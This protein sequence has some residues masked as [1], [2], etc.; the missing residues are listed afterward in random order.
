[1]IGATFVPARRH[2][3]HHV[4]DLDTILEVHGQELDL[5]AVERAVNGQPITL[6][7]PEQYE[8]ARQLGLLGYPL[9]VIA[10]RTGMNLRQVGR[11]SAVGWPEPTPT[12]TLRRTQKAA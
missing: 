11:W 5:A 2:T 9:S 7:G 3:Y 6:T 8:A 1:M 10:A 12:A 4:F